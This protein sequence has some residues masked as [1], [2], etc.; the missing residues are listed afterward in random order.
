MRFNGKYKTTEEIVNKYLEKGSL[1]YVE[2]RIK[3]SEYTDKEGIKKKKTSIICNDLKI[4]SY[5]KTEDNHNDY[6]PGF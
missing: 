5:K 4:L 2:G 1:V 3:S 6:I